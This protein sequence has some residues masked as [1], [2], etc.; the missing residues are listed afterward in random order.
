MNVFHPSR[1]HA[2]T[3]AVAS[4]LHRTLLFTPTSRFQGTQCA[5]VAHSIY[6]HIRA[7]VRVRTRWNTWRMPFQA[8][9]WLESTASARHWF[10]P[11]ASAPLLLCCFLFLSPSRCPRQLCVHCVRTS[12]MLWAGLLSRSSLTYGKWAGGCGLVFVVYAV[13]WLTASQ[14]AVCP[15]LDWCPFLFL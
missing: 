1:A 6:T 7:R 9:L 8:G 14:P 3:R 5:G 4:C 15:V 10:L 2:A 12:F 11:A 13:G